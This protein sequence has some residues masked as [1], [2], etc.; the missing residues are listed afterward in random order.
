MIAFCKSAIAKY[1]LPIDN[2]PFD[3]IYLL[4]IFVIAYCSLTTVNWILFGYCLPIDQ[5][6]V[7]F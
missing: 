2:L 6:P 5:V 1:L 3:I 4:V 7:T